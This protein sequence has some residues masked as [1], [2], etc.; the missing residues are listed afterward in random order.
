MNSLVVCNHSLEKKR[1]LLLIYTFFDNQ[2]NRDHPRQYDE[3]IVLIVKV[4]C[5][6]RG[7]LLDE[8]SFLDADIHTLNFNSNY[9]RSSMV[10]R[11]LRKKN[12]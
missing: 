9:K 3:R 4:A 10:L 11:S 1:G 12:S 7:C 2:T 8:G 6:K 5:R